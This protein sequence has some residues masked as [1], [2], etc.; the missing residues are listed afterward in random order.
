[1]SSFGS[2]DIPMDT[3]SL[4]NV[5]SMTGAGSNSYGFD[6][7]LGSVDTSSGWN[8]LNAGLM[9]AGAGTM[10]N[11]FSAADS[12]YVPADSGISAGALNGDTSFAMP[13]G[14]SG[15]SLSQLQSQK[16]GNALGMGSKLAQPQ[17]SNGPQATGS[18]RV[19]LQKVQFGNPI[20]NFGGAFGGSQAGNSLMQLLARYH[21]GAQ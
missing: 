12:N 11:G 3:S 13:S 6:A 8:G 5:A 18:G 19:R 16:L 1:M 9:G 21:P 7:G 10:P 15:A 14:G 20:T 2:S 4:S 17:T